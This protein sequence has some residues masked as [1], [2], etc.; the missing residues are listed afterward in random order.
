MR[1]K[2]SEISWDAG[3]FR[4]FFNALVAEAIKWAIEQRMRCV[5]LSP[6]TDVSKTRCGASAVTTQNAV[7]VSSERRGQLVFRPL[8][9]L[10][11]RSRQGNVLGSLVDRA[12]R[13]G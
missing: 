8:T 5:N 7:L 3:Y 13:F 4:F 9:E 10:N 2:Y 12:R 1:P 6:G 11:E